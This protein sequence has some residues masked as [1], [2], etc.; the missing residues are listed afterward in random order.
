MTYL[1]RRDSNQPW[2]STNGL[3]VSSRTS[4]TVVLTWRDENEPVPSPTTPRN[5]KNVAG[6]SR[7]SPS[8]SPSPPPTHSPRVRFAQDIEIKPKVPHTN[9]VKVKEPDDWFEIQ[10]RKGHD[11][12]WRTVYQ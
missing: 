8:S 1:E 4:R 6:P 12:N 5:S 9:L 3:Q 10:M 7:A 2:I 11:K